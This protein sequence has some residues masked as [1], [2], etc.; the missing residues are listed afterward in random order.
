[1][2]KKCLKYLNGTIILT[3]FVP[4][5]PVKPVIFVCNLNE[6]LLPG[7]LSRAPVSVKAGSSL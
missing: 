1:M 2:K 5:S 6:T 7:K 4:S 3:S